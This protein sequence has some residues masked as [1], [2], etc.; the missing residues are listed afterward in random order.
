MLS[1]IISPL[2]FLATQAGP[3]TEPVIKD[4]A[5]D[6]TVIKADDGDYYLYATEDLRNVPIY[7]SSDLFHWQL[8]GTVFD[9]YSRPQWNQKGG[10]WAPDINKVGGQYVLYYSKSEWG[11]DWTCGIG[12]ATAPSPTGPFTDHGCLFIS[13]EIG[14]R[15]SIDPFFIEDDGRKYLFWGS[16]HG[17]YG[18]EL[19]DDGLRIKKGARK[20]R[21]AGNF[22]EGTYI[23]K[24]GKYYY[25]F[26]SEGSCCAGERSTYRV[27]YGRSEHLFGP[28]RT[29]EGGRML[30]GSY[31]VLVEG[32]SL[33]AGPGHN[34][35]IVTDSEGR[36]WMPVH[37]YERKHPERG[38]QVWMLRIGWQ[39]G[40]PGTVGQ[41]EKR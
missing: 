2:M 26:G 10:I 31:D 23:H 18:I 35:E 29:K 12:V 1:L 32:D 38:R 11:G 22:M 4:S 25:L 9:D 15:N 6:P 34:A 16:F 33:V 13:K 37:G 41:E 17:I 27:V 3:F 24:R 7:R 39:D 8:A 40:W 30:R 21:I 14:V 28:Y 36:D 19:T 20:K 5:P